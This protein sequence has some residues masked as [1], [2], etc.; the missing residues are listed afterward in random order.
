MRE[1]NTGQKYLPMFPLSLMLLPGEQTN[2]MLFEPK[3]LQLHK[4]LR[5][6]GK[7]VIP[8]V[9]GDALGKI[10]ALSSFVS[11]S[12]IHHDGKIDV[13]VECTSIVKI[14]SFE[15]THPGKLYAGGNVQVK[16]E[17]SNWR[18]NENLLMEFEMLRRV[19]GERGKY[20]GNL[21][22]SY[23]LNILSFLDSNNKDK[24][25]FLMMRDQ[26]QQERTLTQMV[27]FARLVLNQEKEQQH[28]FFMN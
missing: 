19:F 16:N 2:L 21:E 11:T 25:Q 26:V 28:G 20:L 27:R 4:D 7:F 1:M 14:V 24:Y 22:Y 18:A 10:G 17:Y 6:G 8:F 3:Y 12:K 5:S 23:V 13:V 9:D 15:T